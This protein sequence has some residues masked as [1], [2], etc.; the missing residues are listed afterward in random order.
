VLPDCSPC[1]WL[2]WVATCLALLAVSAGH[3]ADTPRD[4]YVIPDTAAFLKLLDLARPD[5]AAVKAALD[6][7]DVAAAGQ[8]YVAHFRQQQI[9][10]PLLTGVVRASPRHRLR[11]AAPSAS[12]WPHHP[13]R[14][15]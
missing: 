9:A 2:L 14:L 10:S 8:A 11:P 1:S 5:L 3:S 12:Q 4:R 13:H 7:N 6:R 15:G